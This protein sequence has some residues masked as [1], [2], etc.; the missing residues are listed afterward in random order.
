MPIQVRLFDILRKKSD[1]L[2]SKML[3]DILQA[4]AISDDQQINNAMLKEL[5]CDY[6]VLEKRNFELSQSLL[7][8]QAKIDED[9]QAA[10]QIQKSLLPKSIPHNDN[11]NFFWQYLPCDK[12]GGDLVNVIPYDEEN[13]IF[14]LVDVSGHGA[15]A[16]MITVAVSQFLTPGDKLNQNIDFLRP[17]AVLEV[18]EKEFPFSRFESF[19]TIIYGVLNLTSGEVRFCNSAH[20]FPILFEEHQNTKEIE[21]HD[22]MLGLGLCPKWTEVT[23]SLAGKKNLFLYTDGLVEC[24]NES[25]DQFSEAKLVSSIEAAKSLKGNLLSKEVEENIKKFCGEIPLH[26]DFTYLHI[27]SNI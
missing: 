17:S 13:L 11:F 21:K 7:E 12:M 26:D 3:E 27:E 20:P 5:V 14:Y 22:P 6:A 16:A 18:M 23:L 8:K 1:H 15:R 25:G 19:F 24:K 10:G 4:K 2:D 9:L